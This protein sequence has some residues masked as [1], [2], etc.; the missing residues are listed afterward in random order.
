MT[1]RSPCSNSL[2]DIVTNSSSL[3]GEE[4]ELSSSSS[5]VHCSVG[6]VSRDLSFPA[7]LFDLFTGLYYIAEVVEEYT[8][9]TQKVISYA[10]KVVIAIHVLLFI[11]DRLPFLS[12]LCGITLHI[13]YY[14][15]LKRFPYISFL[16]YEFILSVGLLIAIHLLWFRFFLYDPRCVNISVEWVL[17]FMLVTVWLVPF[18]FFI[19]LASNDSVL[20]M[21]SAPSQQGYNRA[22][23]ESSRSSGGR[24]RGAF[25]QILKILRHKRDEVLP[26]VSREISMGDFSKNYKRF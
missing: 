16:S 6:G 18:A 20:P 2:H 26:R 11:V 21:G 8:K 3:G 22:E 17:G 9:F 14:Q 7:I 1:D 5:Y 24:S 13:I 15:L 19:S 12:I 25:L 10:I 4:E 23:P